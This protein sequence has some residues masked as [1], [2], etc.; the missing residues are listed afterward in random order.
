MYGVWTKDQWQIFITIAN[1]SQNLKSK[2]AV[3]STKRQDRKQWKVVNSNI[4]CSHLIPI[5]IPRTIRVICRKMNN[6]DTF[7]GKGECSMTDGVEKRMSD[8]FLHRC[9]VH[10][11]RIWTSISSVGIRHQFFLTCRRWRVESIDDAENR[12][13]DNHLP[14]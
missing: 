1:K 14:S 10:V 4:Q 9:E 8:V 3:H 6:S 7:K 13:A 5:V 2:E 11:C 12:N